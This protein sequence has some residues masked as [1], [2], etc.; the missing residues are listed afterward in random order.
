MGADAGLA[1]G[2]DG[3][4]LHV[5]LERGRDLALAIFL[6]VGLL[7]AGQDPVGEIGAGRD[8]VARREVEP[9]RRVLAH[10]LSSL[11]KPRSVIARSTRRPRA[12]APARLRLGASRLGALTRPASI[13]AWAR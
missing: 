7:D 5:A 11:M 12:C 9:G 2:L 6:L 10:D 1:E 3:G 4:V 13:A 8:I